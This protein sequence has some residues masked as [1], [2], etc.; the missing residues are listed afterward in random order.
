MTEWIEIG[1][2]KLACGDCRDIMPEL[3][4]HS[5]DA[6]ITDPPYAKKYQ[7]LYS[8]IAYQLPHLLLDG[9]SFLAIVPHFALPDVLRDVEKHLKYRWTLCMWQSG[10][11]QARMAMGIRVM[12]KPIVWWVNRAWPSGRG[13]R[14]D[15][16]ESVYEPKALHKWQQPMSW[17]EYCVEFVP[18][19]LRSCVLDPLMGAGTSA[20]AAVKAGHNFIGIEKDRKTFDTACERIREWS[21]I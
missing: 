1:P 21:A 20:I 12:W 6:V 5:I 15:G 16:F 19:S 13:F 2:C 10:G 4:R 11:P 3:E 8:D 7:Y 9:G 18:L 17:A 14:P